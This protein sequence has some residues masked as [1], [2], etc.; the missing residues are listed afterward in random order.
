VCNIYNYTGEEAQVSATAEGKTCTQGGATVVSAC[1]TSGLVG[2]CLN[3]QGPN[4]TSNDCVYYAGSN[5][6]NECTSN[7]G[8][9]ST[10]P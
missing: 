6:Q 10:T 1:P 7:G 5:T 8:T 3:S 4:L 9:W 2:C